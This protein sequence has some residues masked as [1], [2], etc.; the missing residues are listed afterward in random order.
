MSRRDS[1]SI[2]TATARRFA[3][4]G[5]AAFLASDDAAAITAAQADGSWSLVR[6]TSS[7]ATSVR[8]RR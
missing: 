3:E 6:W 8:A 4:E 7:A 5:A 2:G 1:G